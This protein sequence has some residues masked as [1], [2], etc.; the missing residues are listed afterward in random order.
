MRQTLT[1]TRKELSAYFGSPMALIFVG[2]FL[3]V[4][5]FAFFWVDAFFARGI[6]DA[7][8]LFQWMPVLMIFLVAA[9]T[10]RQWSEEQRSG[11]LELLLTMPV[12][13]LQ[14]VI[15]KFLA[16]MALV[17]LALA[18]TLVLPITVSLL[19][20]LDWGPVVGGYV[21]A[22]LMAAAY[23]AIG[24]FISSRTDNQI[25]S[26]ILTVLLGGLFYL[27][28]S[29]GVTDFVAPVIGDILR[30]LGAGSR[31]DSIE[32]GVIDLRD[33]A[34]YLT[35]TGIFLTLNVLSL[36][37]KRWSAG[38]ATAAYRRRMTLTSLLVI[39]N[40]ALV[41]V[42]LYPLSMLRADLTA[43]HAYSLSQTTRDL[44]QSL[45]EPLTIR[46]Y[47]SEQ[48]HPLLKPLVPQITDLLREYEIAGRGKV[49]AEVVDPIKDPEQETE[50]NQTYGIQPTPFQVAGRHES[51]VINSYFDILVRY[52]DQHEVLNF[53]DLVEVEQLR[54]GTVDVRLRNPEYDLTRTIK[55]AVYGFQSVDQL[56][57]SLSQPVKLTLLVTTDTL[58][59]SLQAAPGMI[60]KVAEEYQAK[61][62]GK[63]S[64]AMINPD[65]PGAALDRQQVLDTYKLRPIART[66]FD[67]QGYYLDMVL[68]TGDQTAAGSD[69]SQSNA[70]SAPQLLSPAGD[71]TEADVRTAIESALKRS[72]TGFL[73]TVG[74]WTPPEVPTQN[75]FGQSQPPLRSWQ[76]VRD[77]LAQDY[78][79]K[80][81]TLSTG[82]VPP[83]VDVLVVISPQ[84][85]GDKE[86]YA[87]DQYLMRGGSV[88]IAEGS[89]VTSV[90]ELAGQL[91]LQ[92]VQGGL[93][94]L[95]ASYGIQV[96]NSLVMDPQNEPFPAQVNRQVGQM[97]VQEIQALPYPFFVD[98]RADGM[99]Q[100]NPVVSKLAA[101]TVNYAS[102]INADDA[103]NQGRQV[104]VLLKSSPNSWLRTNGDITPDLQKYPGTGFPVEGDLAGRPLAVAVTGSFQSFFKDK[105][106][107]LVA[108]SEITG[109]AQTA[110]PAPESQGGGTIESSPETARLL[111]VGSS[112]FLTDL[113]FQ[114]SSGL[115][116]DRYLNS[117]QFLQNAVDWSVE[118]LDLLGIRSR[119]AQVRI[120]KPM[121]G[122]QETTWEGVDYGLV[123]LALIGIGLAW[124]VRRKQERPITLAKPEGDKQ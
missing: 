69:G 87:I 61:S 40:L 72:S 47:I 112:D 28:G 44:L 45:S 20:T 33:L 80:P 91:A 25:V 34:Y 35:L 7:R 22:L 36:D 93:T 46:A 120:L 27:V 58:P 2:V 19:G 124:Y 17:A 1:I 65:T 29:R 21:A 9:L 113:I 90:D 110:N 14:L 50:A 49:T 106:S 103:S 8:P 88:V 122:A 92:P 23:A 63:F 57:A 48:T 102:P 85:M 97:V 10:M 94:D 26:L 5:L 82:Q 3:A 121:T 39:A 38:Q 76:A 42:W 62:G 117:L 115:S 56:L 73:K 16:V 79:V 107:P 83:D 6:A 95:L 123:L 105:P 119:G 84:Q 18:L 111:V 75:M 30:A 41:N 67:N 104:D 54:D 37:S 55:K 81:V 12:S 60:Q 13:K 53:R 24:L 100:K 108:S 101:V 78:T 118:D 98:V 15:G 66:L 70:S 11:T 52:G 31:F 89:Y 74:L 64:F 51:S 4:T 99:D 86:K 77:R 71:Y 43:E 68:D 59:D 96:E 116:Q 114:I 32:R 109:T